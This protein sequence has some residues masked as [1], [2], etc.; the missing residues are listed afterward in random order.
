MRTAA[1]LDTGDALGG[2][3]AGAH[4]IFRIP[5]GVDVIGDRGDLVFATQ[6][7][8]QRIH[9]RGL[10]RTDGAADADPQGSV[11]I[12]ANLPLR[13]QIPAAT[14]LTVLNDTRP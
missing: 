9:Q 5:L 6:P 8:A 12:H 3:R 2:K 1:G 11:G 14:K 4:E 10:A 7:L 13:G